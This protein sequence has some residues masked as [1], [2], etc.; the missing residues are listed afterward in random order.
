MDILYGQISANDRI[1]LLRSGVH[2]NADLLICDRGVEVANEQGAV[3]GALLLGEH[4]SS[5]MRL[6]PLQWPIC[7]CQNS[8]S[9]A[10]P[11]RML[12]SWRTPC[13]RGAHQVQSIN[14]G[15]W[16]KAFSHPVPSLEKHP[17]ASSHEDCGGAA[18]LLSRRGDAVFH[19]FGHAAPFMRACKAARPHQHGGRLQRER[20][21]GC[22][23]HRAIGRNDRGHGSHAPRRE[24]GCCVGRGLRC[25]GRGGGCRLGGSGLRRTEENR[26]R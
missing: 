15:G 25:G 20:S 10:L 14:K 6:W 5:L 9:A 1:A 17:R 8:R 24:L 11:M 18:L 7:T 2:R 19:C 12:C 22:V 16:R 13:I 3:Q 4:D 21:I 26:E 23:E